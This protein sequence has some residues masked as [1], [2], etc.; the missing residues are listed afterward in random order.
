M[1]SA[2]HCIALNVKQRFTNSHVW[3][4]VFVLGGNEPRFE[5]FNSAEF[6]GDRREKMTVEEFLERSKFEL[7]YVYGEPIGED[8]VRE[9]EIPDIVPA[10]VLENKGNVLLWFSMCRSISSLHV[11][12]TEGVLAQIEGRK[13]IWFF[14]PDCYDYLYPYPSDH[15]K[16]RQSQIKDIHNP[17]LDEFPLFANVSAK[18]TYIDIGPGEYVRIP[19]GWWHQV[20]VLEFPSVSLSF[21][22]NPYENVLRSAALSRKEL[23]DRGAPK[24]AADMVCSEIIDE[25]MPTE[26]SNIMKKRLCS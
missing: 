25:G 21:R 22:W 15:P 2:R 5:F 1:K 11:D 19:F 14:P 8:I 3:N 7:L 16:D 23:L 4:N 13:R 20:E 17:D 6:E 10:S 26:L 18:A 9:I 12:F 24:Y